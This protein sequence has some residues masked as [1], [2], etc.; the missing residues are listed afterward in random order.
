MLAG[1]TAEEKKALALSDPGEYKFLTKVTAVTFS[2]FTRSR[3]TV[4]F[5]GATCRRARASAARAETTRTCIG[6]SAPRWSCSSRRASI[7]TFSS[8]W[9]P[10]CTWGTSAS[11]V[12]AHTHILV[13]Y[14]WEET[15]ILTAVRC[16]TRKHS[17]KPGNLPRQQIQTLQRRGL[18]AGGELVFRSSWWSLCGS[19]DSSSP[20]A[21]PLKVRKSLLNSSLTSRSITTARESVSKPLSS[22]QAS[23]CRD[24]FVKVGALIQPRNVHDCNR[25]IK[26][27]LIPGNL[28]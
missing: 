15:V 5:T 4:A 23:D 21:C 19:R 24:A 3:N 1:I 12:S 9:Q 25:W 10:F 22:R 16:G 26:C 11:R 14:M 27:D 28:Q 2:S 13:F 7:R 20:H 18:S 6:T 17:G 8:C